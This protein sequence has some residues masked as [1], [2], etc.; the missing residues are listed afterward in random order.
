MQEAGQTPSHEWVQKRDARVP[1]RAYRNLT[2]GNYL[3]ALHQLQ[4]AYLSWERT[5]TVANF[6][7]WALNSVD[8]WDTAWALSGKGNVAVLPDT[9]ALI[10]PEGAIAAALSDHH[11]VIL[12]EAHSKPETRYF[13]AR[14]LHALRAAGAT[15]L[16][17]ETSRQA[18]PPWSAAVRLRL[19][20]RRPS[21]SR[22]E[23]VPPWPPLRRRGHQPRARAVHGA[24]HRPAAPQ[25]RTDGARRGLDRRAA[26]HEAHPARLEMAASLH[27]RAPRS[28]HRRRT[29][30]RLAGMCGLASTLHPPQTPHH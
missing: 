11:V 22:A 1:L 6:L 2:A 12:M 7:L 26:R 4:H 10:E 21:T 23:P 13:G 30:L 5:P 20:T 29:L 25:A 19:R 15:H 3:T 18:T 27:G 24:Q 8:P 9:S 17:F 14:L 28:P 16:A